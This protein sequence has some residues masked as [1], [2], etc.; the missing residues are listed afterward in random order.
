MATADVTREPVES[1]PHTPLP[2]VIP[3]VGATEDEMP[4]VIRI[5]WWAYLR[6]MWNLFWS[7]IRHP[8][9]ETTIDLSTGRVLYRA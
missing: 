5:P 3:T 7:A 6:S 8:F 2:G 9:S 1:D 4:T